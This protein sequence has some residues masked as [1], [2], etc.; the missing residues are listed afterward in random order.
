[1]R[2]PLSLR[3]RLVVL[4][5]ALQFAGSALA[6]TT[7][8]THRILNAT[9]NLATSQLT[10]QGVNFPA[11]VVVVLNGE[12][13]TVTSVGA[14]SIV[15]TLPSVIVATP[16]TYALTLEKPRNTVLSRFDVTIGAVGAQGPQGV[17]GAQ[18]PAG[19]EGAV[20]PM[21]P[22]GPTGATG[23]QGPAG[24]TTPPAASGALFSGGVVPVATTGWSVVNNGST[25]GETTDNDFSPSV[26]TIAYLQTNPGS[27]VL[28]ASVSAP[29]GTADT[30]T[31]ALIDGD[32]VSGTGAP[33][34]S[35]SVNL[36][37]ASNISLLA[38]INAPAAD[39]ISLNCGTQ[40]IDVGGITATL[41][42]TPVTWSIFGAFNNGVTSSGG[43]T[44]TGW[45][46]IT[47]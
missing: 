19:Q 41:V 38:T 35:S 24:S 8:A 20:G 23:P 36:E 33:L 46:Q 32:N 12:P 3:Q 30:L 11:D 5:A 45:N 40:Q 37:N 17:A 13:L 14:T 9:A 18:G 26:N 7:D 31:C 29:L 44:T 6:Q 10:L 22:A 4:G 28:Q 16:G 2:V 42:I 43:P 34:A 25:A 15:A 39:Q 47:N 27:Y 1:M 21:G